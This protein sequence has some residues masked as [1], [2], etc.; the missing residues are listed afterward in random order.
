MVD[1]PGADVRPPTAASGPAAPPTA[2]DAPGASQVGADTKRYAVLSAVMAGLFVALFIS[3]L[4]LLHRSPGLG[5]PDADYAQFY[6]N[7]GSRILLTVGTVLVPFAGIAFLWHVTTIRLLIRERT[8]V[9]SAIPDGLHILSG[10]IFVVLLFSG[11]GAAGAM[12]LLMDL[13]NAGLPSVAVAR[14]LAGLGYG[15]F[16]IF[17]IRGAGMYAIT[18]TTL[19]MKARLL[20]RWVA[21]VGYLLAAVLLVST[22]FNPVIVL[23]FPAWMVL[24]SVVVLIEARRPDGHPVPD[25][26]GAV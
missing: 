22:T 24:V 2:A 15:I 21:V 18:T 13:T 17:A 12:A 14:A 8:P 9:P 1:Q 20:P 3:A 23:V 19:L 16:F 25:K 5:V 7:G 10:I 26:E 11:T 4:L 6:A